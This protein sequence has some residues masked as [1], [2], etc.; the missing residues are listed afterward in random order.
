MPPSDILAS[1]AN[2]FPLCMRWRSLM[3][4]CA[5]E[6]LQRSAPGLDRGGPRSLL[7]TSGE[8]A[9]TAWPQCGK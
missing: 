5:E 6:R 4:A 1:L 3:R 7:W 8:G 9:R 2:V